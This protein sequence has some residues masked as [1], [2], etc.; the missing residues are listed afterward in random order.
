MNS[1]CLN[2]GADLS[3]ETH[4][5]HEDCAKSPCSMGTLIRLGKSRNPQKFRLI[6]LPESVHNFKGFFTSAVLHTITSGMKLPAWN[7]RFRGYLQAAPV[8]LLMHEER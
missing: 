2:G 8:E 4:I 7:K 6:E 3:P 1:I 5:W